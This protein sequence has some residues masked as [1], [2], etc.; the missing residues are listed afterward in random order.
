MIKTMKKYSLI[1]VM[2][3]FSSLLFGQGIYNNGG[4]IVIGSGVTLTVSGSGGNYRNETGGLLNLFGSMKL[5][6]NLTNNAAADVIGTAGVGSKIELNGSAAQTIGGT[7]SSAF[8]FPD[9]VV[10]NTSGVTFQKDASVTGALSL[11]NGLVNIGNNNFTLGAASTIVGTP[12]ASSM[13]VATGTGQ[14]QKA[15]TTTGS[16]TFPVGDNTGTAEYSPVTLSFGA[17]TFA[18]GSFVGVNLSNSKFNSLS[19]AGSYLNRYW[20]ITQTGISGFNSNALFQYAIAD[21]QGTESSISCFKVDSPPFSAYDQANTSLHQ[22]SASGLGLFGTFTGGE[23]LVAPI[24]SSTQSICFGS[25]ASLSA[26]AST[27]GSGVFTYQWQSSSDNITFTDISLANSLNFSTGALFTSTYYRLKASEANFNPVYSNVV[28]VTA[29]NPISAPIISSTTQSVCYNTAP[30]NLT[31][32][33]ASGGTGPFI[34]QWQMKTTGSWSS[35][36]SGLTYSPGNLTTTTSF[37]LIAID[38]GS[39]SCGSVISNIFVVNVNA[40]TLPGSIGTGVLQII[41]AANTPNTINSV[42]SGTGSGTITYNWEYSTDGST[43]LPTGISTASYSPGA[44]SQSTFYR[45]KAIS[46]FNGITCESVPSATVSITVN[47]VPVLSSTLSPAAICSGGT[48]SYTATSSTSG[49]SFAWS[50]ATVSGISESGISGTGNIS[51]VLTNTTALP[52]NVTYAYTTSANSCSSVPQNVVVTLNPSPVLTST[53]TPASI[54]SAGTFSYTATS[55]VPSATILWSRATISGISE[56]G[57]NGS[58]NIN[59]VLTNSTSTPINVTYVY[60]LSTNFCSSAPQ[61]VIVTVNPILPVSVSISASATSVCAGTPVTY[62]ALPVNKGTL[63]VYQWYVGSTPVGTSSSTFTYIPLNGDAISV[64]LTSNAS[65]CATGSPAI[66][67]TINMIVD[68]LTT[69]IGATSTDW[70]TPANWC[71]GVLPVSTIDIVIPSGAPNMPIIGTVGAICRNITINAGASLSINAN[72]TLSLTGNIVNN[73]TL[74]MN[75]GST[76]AMNGSAAQTIKGGLVENF[77]NLTINN[78]QGVTMLSDLNVN[79]TLNLASGTF[80]IGTNTLTIAGNSPTAS[81]GNLDASNAAS[82]LVFNNTS[83]ISLPAAMFSGSVNNLTINGVGGVIAGSNIT[84]NGVLNLSASNPS[85]TKGLLEMTRS[86]IGYPGTT[87]NTYLDSWILNMGASATT[88]GIGDVTG[89]VKRSTIV[90]NTPYSFGNQYTTIALSTGTMPSDISVSITIGATPPGKSNAVQRTYEILP[91]GG[92]NCDVAAN[93]HYLDSELASSISP[94]FANTEINMVTWDYDIGGGTSTPDEHGRSDYDFTNNFVGMAN[95]PID[96]FINTVGHTWRT[97]FTLGNFQN[98]YYTWNGST[99]NAWGTATNWTPNGV[100]SALSHVIIPDAAATPNDPVLPA[101]KSSASVNTM[102]IQNGGILVMANNTIY[103]QNTLSGGWED[104]NPLGNDPGTSKVIFSASGASISGNARF[105]DVEIGA[106]AD[107]TNMLGNTMKIANSITKSGTGKWFADIYGATIEYNGGIQTVL[108]PDGVFDYHHLILSGSGTKT[109]PASALNIHGDMTI[110]GTASV[111][112]G[113]SITMGGNLTLGTG[114]SFTAGS[115]TH[116]IAGNFVNN[117]TTLN[118]NGSTF[119]FNGISTQNIGGTVATSFNS[120]SLNNATGA[121]LGNSVAVNGTLTL[122]NGILSLGSNNLTLGSAAVAGT[123]SATNMI[124]TDGSGELRRTFSANGSYLF[125][126]G[127]VTGTVEYSPVTLNFTAGT[128][129]GGAYAGVKLVNAAYADPYITGSYL[130][131]YWTVSQSGISAFS[132]NPTFQYLPA[133]VVGTENN[134]FTARINPSPVTLFNA[135]N[136]SLHQLTATSVSSFGSF[137]GAQAS[138]YLSLKVFLEGPYLGAGTMNTTLKTNSLIP[139]AHPYSGAPWNVAAAPASSIPAGVVDW[140]LVE[141]RDAATPAAALSATTLTGWPNA[142]F[143]KADG[144][145]VDLDG[146]SL[147]NI[148][149]PTVNNNLYVI[150]RHRNHLAIMSN[151]GATLTGDTYSYDFTSSLTQA[152]GGGTGYKQL[153]TGVF[154]MVTGDINHDGN[155]FVTDY[156]AWAVQF[157]AT[158]TYSN[159]DLNQDGNVFVTDYNKWAVNFGNTTINP[160]LLKSADLKPLYISC[161]PK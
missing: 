30:A 59:E 160:T 103:I 101:G 65:P 79:N 126:V 128:Y 110:A 157:G 90:A 96:Y 78:I 154:G 146:T 29:N 129:A 152:Y 31:A 104:Q 93:F 10:N 119:N 81:G 89:T 62:T 41:C 3:L 35:V 56:A 54:C 92:S 47:P 55:N 139:L 141:L 50:R 149:N 58:G 67:N 111:A 161:V 109:M 136:T 120:L 42:S 18:P 88:I 38:N 155:V 60:T 26:T 150:V 132:C 130:N 118:S 61:N 140:V 8:T 20:N 80:S 22:L 115:F 159:S 1:P 137:T 133:D 102:T 158:N 147:P 36:G 19:I 75:T 100:P 52:I 107:I 37:Q 13:I 24:A 106:G 116:N 69:W 151:T 87:N 40:Q 76:V 121:N 138:K 135:A 131:R 123:P 98:A 91:T 97:V 64:A 142:F 86:Y 122:T 124:V 16:F 33:V 70:N 46:N 66:S 125:P 25:S 15:W 27:G 17:G 2:L 53:L 48:F 114:T 134:L 34:Y 11:T 74:N 94:F 23:T 77:G 82:M 73:G 127:D 39:P 108:H 143:L 14:V 12:S 153:G 85:T 145:I 32:T 117:G 113:G 45:R 144:S 68:P 4:K 49:A 84:V 51:E 5:G 95:I 28:L 105:Y 71:S 63:P 112:P 6:G 44:L 83:A 7:T 99:S 43:W 156:N 57:T 21:V 148:G 9:L 72:S